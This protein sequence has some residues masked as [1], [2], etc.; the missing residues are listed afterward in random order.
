MGQRRLTSTRCVVCGDTIDLTVT[1]RA[2]RK[3][4]S[5]TRRCDACRRQRNFHGV[6]A[7][8]IARRDGSWC[9][10]CGDPVDLSLLA[11]HPLSPSI[12][13]V[14]AAR[15]GGGNDQLQLSH[16]RCNQR[17]SVGAVE[18][19]P[20]TFYNARRWRRLS[21]SVRAAEPTCRLCGGPSFCAGHIVPIA[22][23]GDP[24]E[25]SNIQA[26]CRTCRNRKA[27]SDYQARAHRNLEPGTT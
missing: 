24:W 18:S 2:G 4:R 3:R 20:S 17:K 26:L 23:G 15:F 21:Q 9:V 27:G 7:K 22:D 25:L 8:V 12:D 11:P 1:G 14:V 5:D 19:T 16:L 6:S 13:R 10:L